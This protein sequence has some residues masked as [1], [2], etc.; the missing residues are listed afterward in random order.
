MPDRTNPHVAADTADDKPGL[1]FYEQERQKLK[2]A[3][4]KKR[5]IE[6]GLQLIEDTIYEKEGMYLENSAQ[7]NIITGFDS[8]TKGGSAP[9]GASRKPRQVA[10]ANRVFSR[11]SISYR[12]DLVS[13]FAFPLLLSLISLFPRTRKYPICVC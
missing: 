11:S 4:S 1:P 6:R 13:S 7:G 2:R 12:Q 5:E 8:Y 10:D 9:A 3:L